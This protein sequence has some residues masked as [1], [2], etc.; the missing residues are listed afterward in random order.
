MIASRIAPP[1]PAAA[2]SAAR[3]GGP[4]L[5]KPDLLTRA[6]PGAWRTLSILV[7]L[8]L[9]SLLDRQILSLLILPIQAD[10]Q[11]TDTQLGAVQGLAFMAFY[12]VMGVT[13]GWAVDRYSRRWI[14]F[15]GVV[16][17]SFSTMACGLSHSFGQ[18]FTARLGVGFGEAVLAP[19]AASLMGAL[20]PR[21]RLSL[22]NGIYNAAAGGG[23]L[24]AFSLGG[25][26][27]VWLQARGGISFPVVGHLQPWQGVFF[28]TGLTGLPLSLLAFLMR[29]QRNPTRAATAPGPQ[30][31]SLAAFARRRGV[32][33]ACHA[34]GSGSLFMCAYAVISWTPTFLG[35]RFGADPKTIGLVMGLSFGFCGAISQIGWGYVIDRLF[36]RGRQDIHY[37]IY[38]FLVPA[39]VVLSALAYT[40][41]NLLTSAILI[42]LLWLSMGMGALWAAPLLFTPPPLRA[43]VSAG[44]SLIS[45]MMGIGLTPFLV[46]FVTDHIFHDRGQVGLSI[47]AFVA[48]CGAFGVALLAF[49]GPRLRTA[50]AEENPPIAAAVV[51]APLALRAR[52][53]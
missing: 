10:L 50:I 22:V 45:G 14:V 36:A 28:L 44:V 2:A 40:A 33:W 4:P 6:A 43:R 34:F 12:S 15:I 3:S 46:G 53:G 35:R 38:R 7:T 17:W 30:T 49:A 42:C 51:T 8:Y 23:G 37:R 26:L 11:L 39:M 32:L 52:R 24:V 25:L 18:L 41:S 1:T 31:D 19:S 9:L 5:H 16:I 29:E 48:V 21:D 47:T 20:F 27:T 13:I